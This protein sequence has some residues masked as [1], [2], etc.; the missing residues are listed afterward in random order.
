MMLYCI[1]YV[2]IC[3]VL[4]APPTDA[5]RLCFLKAKVLVLTT[6]GYDGNIK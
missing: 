4:P 3:L 6:D 2:F 1:S 5:V